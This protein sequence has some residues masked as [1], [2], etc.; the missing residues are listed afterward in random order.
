MRI[1]SFFY[2]V[3]YM[4]IFNVGWQYH[5]CKGIRGIWRADCPKFTEDLPNFVSVLIKN[6]NEKEGG[7]SC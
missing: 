7:K 2:I 3:Y 6:K 4:F 5:Y 1:F